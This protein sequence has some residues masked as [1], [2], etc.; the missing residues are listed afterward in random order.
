MGN[1]ISRD[2]S[3]R[4][5]AKRKGIA[6]GKFDLQGVRFAQLATRPE[7]PCSNLCFRNTRRRGRLLDR[8]FLRH[9]N[10]SESEPFLKWCERTAVDMFAS[11][12]MCIGCGKSRARSW[13]IEKRVAGGDVG[14]MRF[15]HRPQDRFRL[16]GA[17][18]RQSGSNPLGY[19]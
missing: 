6:A 12:L 5:P 11:L 9:L 14:A 17:N 1:R 15:M 4:S 19:P 18:A 3:Q 7:K 16:G 13:L 8:E 10:C 2:R